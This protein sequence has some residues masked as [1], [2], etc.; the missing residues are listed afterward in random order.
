MIIHTVTPGDTVW[1]LAHR[2]GVSPS[3]ILS[4]NGIRDPRALVEGQ[5]LV[6]LIPHSTYTVQPGD[7]LR[8]VAEK[9]QMSP[10]QLLQYNPELISSPYL[11]VGQGLMMEPEDRGQKEIS[12]DGCAYA[13]ADPNILRRCLPYLSTVTICD[14][15]YTDAGDIVA[16]EDAS[17]LELAEQFHTAPVLLLSALAENGNFCAE[18]VSALLTHHK[19]QTRLLTQII[20]AMRAKGYVGLAVGLEHIERE[21]A[22]AYPDFLQYAAELL[23]EN[24]FFLR[25][26]LSQGEEIVRTRDIA[27][28]V[29]LTPQQYLFSPP[30]PIAPFNQLQ[31]E[32]EVATR[33]ISPEKI[34]LSFP[35]IG[36]DWT[37]PYRKHM[38]RAIPIGN[39]YA[40]ALAH[41][42]RTSIQRKPS[43]RSPTFEYQGRIGKNHVVW[44]EDARSMEQKLI[45]IEKYGL[46]GGNYWNL[47]QPFEQSWTLLSAKYKIRKLY[48]PDNAR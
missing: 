45:L 44:F 1:N 32:I 20:D 43:S 41:R 13:D 2:Y 25:V 35:N 16:C 6:V 5:A 15:K 8:S 24:E 3:R 26:I 40:V 29:V 12:I 14:Y 23:H 21:D 27:D 28:E 42:Y 4:D 38:T 39:D 47:A 7:T 36:Y 37:L 10:I 17:I 9:F 30:S 19:M 33:E 31:K 48:R 46:R 22:D 18:K 11:R 34:L